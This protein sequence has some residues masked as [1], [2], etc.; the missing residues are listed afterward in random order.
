MA[1]GILFGIIILVKNPPKKLIFEKELFLILVVVFLFT[2]LTLVLAFLS[3]ELPS[4]FGVEIFWMILPIVYAFVILNTFR[5]ED[6]YFCVVI[7]FFASLLG[8][9]ISIG[10]QNFTFANIMSVN[11]QR[12]FSPFESHLFEMASLNFA[13]FFAYYRKHKILGIIATIFA[14]A[15]FKRYNFIFSI[16]IF[17]LPLLIDVNRTVTIKAVRLLKGGL[18]A[19]TL[20][21]FWLMHPSTP[22]FFYPVFGRQR[23]D[24][25][26][27]RSY[28]LRNILE[29]DFVSSGLA[30]TTDFL[31]QQLE[32]DMIKIMLELSIFALIV[33]IF[34]YMNLAGRKLFC[35]IYMVFLL[36]RGVFQLVL[37]GPF[38]WVIAF[39]VI[40]TVNYMQPDNLEY[41][42]YK[43]LIQRLKDNNGRRS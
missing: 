38:D 17:F 33:L 43:P 16:V 1:L 4:R 27:G 10:P 35:V 28:F 36:T 6:I 41:V 3:G 24:F 19:F 9:V 5:F 34:C 21:Y 40:G 22:D 42:N 8:Y 12:S 30:S 15:V 37:S 2:F 11:F 31:R 20:F 26:M 25:T 29:G 32:M 7:A 23:G 14:I 18:I 39:L 13:V